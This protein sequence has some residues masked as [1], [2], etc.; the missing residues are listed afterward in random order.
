MENGVF[1]G[2]YVGTDYVFNPENTVTRGEF[3]SM[4]MSAAG[5]DL[6]KGVS[7]TGFADD[8][9]IN[10]WLKPYVATALMN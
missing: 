7:T 3:L 4:C 1:T 6:L 2:E 10:A 9:A 5:C 8:D